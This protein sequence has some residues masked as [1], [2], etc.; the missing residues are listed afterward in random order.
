VS[1]SEQA[2]RWS[3][4]GAVIGLAGF[5]AWVSYEHAYHLVLHYQ[6]AAGALA[7]GYPLT[8][9]GLVYVASMV[10]LDS[11]RRDLSTPWLAHLMF[12]VGIGATVTVNAVA[13]LAGGPVRALGDAWPAPVLIASYELLMI[14]LRRGRREDAPE[15]APAPGVHPAPECIPGAPGEDLMF[16]TDH[17][18]EMFYARD[19]SAGNIPSQRKIRADLHVGQPRAKAIHKHLSALVPAP[20]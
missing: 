4:I 12:T 13:G 6:V 20:Q 17:E 10:K 18:I 1:A 19:I 11:A 7:R 9:D 14:I 2:V 15:T 5:A 8:V 16:G 3:A